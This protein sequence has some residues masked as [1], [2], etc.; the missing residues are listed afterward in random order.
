MIPKIRIFCDFD[1]TIAQNDVGNKVFTIF[2]DESNWWRLVDEWKAGKIDG[3]SLWQKQCEITK[4]TENDLDRFAAQQ[5]LDPHFAEF[6]TFCRHHNIPITVL[7]DGM[8]AYIERILCHHGFE[9]LEIRANHL[10]ILEDASLKVEFP[11]FEYG[12]KVCA[13]CK[14]YHIRNLTNDGETTIYIGDGLSD[15]CAVTYADIIFAKGELIEFCEKYNIN[16]LSF[17]TFSD[18]LAGIKRIMS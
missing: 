6:V 10:S 17:K 5:P 3:R 16:Y 8:D 4:I 7:S 9:D 1:G 14:G 13:N 15:R 2:G 18:V 12:C 11:Y